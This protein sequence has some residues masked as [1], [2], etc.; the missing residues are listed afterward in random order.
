MLHVGQI[1]TVAGLPYLVDYVNESR[2]HCVSTAKRTVTVHDRR[3]GTDR[4]F[5]ATER[6]SLD[7]SPNSGLDVLASL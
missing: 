6:K 3:T 5:E 4:T 2:A 1:I 7:I